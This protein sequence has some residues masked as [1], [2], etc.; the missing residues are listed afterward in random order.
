MTRVQIRAFVLE[1]N[2][3]EGIRIVDK[4]EVDALAMFIHPDTIRP[5]DICN[6]VRA[7]QPDAELRERI[8]MDVRIGNYYPPPGGPT[9]G[10][11]LRNLLRS[12]QGVPYLVH[13]QYEKL[14][15]FTDG[16]G[17]S[18]RALWLWMML[19]RGQSI[20]LG[21]LHTWYYQSLEFSR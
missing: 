1:S 16:N 3:I 19:R 7:F 8:G 21:F 9:I 20:K 13:H 12:I 4:K 18:G 15:P 17:R 10:T 11:A 14:H 6:I 2:K 5:A